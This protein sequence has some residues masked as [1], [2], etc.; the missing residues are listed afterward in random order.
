MTDS[1]AYIRATGPRLGGIF[2]PVRS[3]LSGLGLFLGSSPPASEA[4]EAKRRTIVSPGRPRCGGLV[5]AKSPWAPFVGWNLSSLAGSDAQTLRLWACYLIPTKHRRQDCQDRLQELALPPLPL[6][7]AVL[8]ILP[9]SR[10]CFAILH[11]NHR[12]G[13]KSTCSL[14][15]TH[16]IDHLNVQPPSHT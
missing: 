13:K 3:Q 7:S 6:P 14:P 15:H 5:S 1:K 11:G 4:S 10:Q 12:I 8:P 16:A 9:T 2:R